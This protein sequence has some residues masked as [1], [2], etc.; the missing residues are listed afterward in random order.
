MTFWQKADTSSFVGS[1]IWSAPLASAM[2]WRDL[3]GSAQMMVPT[4][5]ALRE[6]IVKAPIGPD[7]L[8]KQQVSLSGLVL[9]LISSPVPFEENVERPHSLHDKARVA[10][11]DAGD[12]GGVPSHGYDAIAGTNS[13]L[14]HKLKTEHSC[15]RYAILTQWLNHGAHV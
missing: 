9:S 15:R 13:Q 5:C 12:L 14:D 6:R 11:F 3:A 4:F 7:P 2:F 1:T 10:S 8:L